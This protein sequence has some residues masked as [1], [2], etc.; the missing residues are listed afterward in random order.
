MECKKCQVDI[1]S[2]FEYVIAKNVCPKC[3]NKLMRQ[4]VMAAY[5]DL[6]NR[7]NEVEFVMDKTTVCERVAMFVVS[8]YEVAPIGGTLPKQQTQVQTSKTTVAL[9]TIEEMESALEEDPNLSPE[10]IRE[11]EAARAEDIATAREMGFSDLTEDEE[12]V[13]GALDSNKVERLKRLAAASKSGGFTVR[14]AD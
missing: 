8:N 14:R 11:Q 9:P 12:L 2:A 1:P 4:E 3:G 13:T 6:K 5:L 7:L 10:E